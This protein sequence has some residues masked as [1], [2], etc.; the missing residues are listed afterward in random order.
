[1][2]L[3]KKFGLEDRKVRAVRIGARRMAPGDGSTLA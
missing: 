2:P 3:P 1:M